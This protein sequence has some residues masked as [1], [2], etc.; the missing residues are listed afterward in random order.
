MKIPDKTTFTRNKAKFLQLLND[1][2]KH[3]FALACCEL[4]HPTLKNW[5][6]NQKLLKQILYAVKSQ[7]PI[8]KKLK[9][10]LCRLQDDFDLRGIDRVNSDSENDDIS[11]A[12]ATFSWAT[13]EVT[14]FIVDRKV[15]NVAL[16][17]S[18]AED[19]DSNKVYQFFL[20]LY[21]FQESDKLY[22]LTKDHLSSNV[23]SL[24]K[25][26]VHPI[27]ADA[28]QDMDYNNPTVLNALRTNNIHTKWINKKCN[29]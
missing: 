23:I 24:A 21:Q 11:S 10:Q 9:R 18:Y 13:T 5:D 7:K 3:L 2:E 4:V 19:I 22:P 12:L 28:L 15:H 27:L 25:Q 26:N 20:E 1:N 6:K 17:A 29:P 8:P 16:V 14:T